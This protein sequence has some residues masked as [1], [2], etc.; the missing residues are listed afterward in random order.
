[1]AQE[2][3]PP[4]ATYLIP[5]F[6]FFF[7]RRS[8]DHESQRQRQQSTSSTVS[9]NVPS[10][11]YS[12]PN[13]L[14]CITC[15]TD[16]A[17]AS[18]I[19]SKGFTG[20]HG[21]AYLV[22]APISLSQASYPPPIPNSTNKDHEWKPDE[23]INTKTG[24]RVNRELLTGMHVV[25]DVSCNICATTLGW[26]YVDA[27]EPSQKYK[28]GKFILEMK[29]VVLRVGWEDVTD[30]EIDEDDGVREYLEEEGE[31]EEGGPVVFD[32][33]DEDECDDLFAGVWD[34]EVVRKRRGRRVGG[35]K[36]DY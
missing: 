34:A 26:K 8:H 27:K 7:R 30:D 3:R 35:W 17:L 15:A 2:P 28:V 4:F 24:R 20:R 6:H 1:M 19:V 23:L 36:R 14:R 16:I 29:R 22:S 9:D 11:S 12:P 10:L 18:Q 21:R 33:E 13:T 25:A 31:G 5:S 32:S